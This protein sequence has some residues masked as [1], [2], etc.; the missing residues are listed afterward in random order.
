MSQSKI[1]LFT[2]CIMIQLDNIY[3][4]RITILEIWAH[5]N[6]H[7][8][9]IIILTYGFIFTSNVDFVP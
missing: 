7:V 4:C 5:M 6:D 8:Y 9:L 2:I 3:T 1:S